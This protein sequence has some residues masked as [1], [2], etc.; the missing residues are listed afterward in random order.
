[1]DFGALPPEINSARMYAGPGSGPMMVAAA[2]WDGLAEDLYSTAS[3]YGAVVS[4]L[5]GGAWSGPSSASMAAAAAAY[6]ASLATTANKA[7]QTAQ[8]ARAAA[9]AYQTAFAMTVPPPSVAANRSLLASLVAS[10][11]FGQ[12]T[13]AIAATEVQY[14]EMWAQDSAAMYGYAQTSAAAAQ[15]TPFAAPAP[16]TNEGGIAA[17]A[18]TAAQAVGSAAG[19]NM[20]NVIATLS[21]LASAIPQSLQSLASP[22]P[23]ESASS[24]LTVLGTL[25]PYAG[26][27]A[28]GIGG[29]GATIGTGAGSVGLVDITLGI[30]G[31]AGQAAVMAAGT[32]GG[33]VSAESG[34]TAGTGLLVSAASP[35]TAVSAAV[36]GANSI[37]ALSVP[38]GWSA[39]AFAAPSATATPIVLTS[40]AIPTAMP[41][42][43]W[44]AM[45]MPQVI[46]RPNRN[47]AQFVATQREAAPR[48]GKH[49]T[50]WN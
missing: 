34:P 6:A 49:S 48:R 38:P 36:G 44:G 24:L 20:Q 16:T 2:A 28:G 7:E 23:A 18:A 21:Q 47:T 14:A 13:P 27:A 43:M 26:V 35:A 3:S 32:T 5:T 10:N 11:F 12:N 30:V 42:A 40:S 50:Q 46:G 9:A 17:Q 31:T 37:G 8:Q 19:G 15:L 39:P 29:I 33:L 4:G 45:P 25:S 41:S 22:A 1:M